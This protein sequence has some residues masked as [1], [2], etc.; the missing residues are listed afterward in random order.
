MRGIFI[1]C[2][3]LCIQTKARVTH[4]C[5]SILDSIAGL[6]VPSII[7]MVAASLHHHLFSWMLFAL[8]IILLSSS[9]VMELAT[10]FC[11]AGYSC[12]IQAAMTQYLMWLM[13]RVEMMHTVYL[14]W[15]YEKV[16]Y[17][18]IQY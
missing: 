8:V 6:I 15:K 11:L 10:A 4:D 13:L 18:R 17:S 14:P 5:A 9:Y 3:L 1:V 2:N 7:H 12:K 16:R